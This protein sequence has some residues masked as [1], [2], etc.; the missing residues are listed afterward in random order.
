MDPTMTLVCPEVGLSHLPT[1]LPNAAHK[2]TDISL[3]LCLAVC[4]SIP[5][6]VHRCPSNLLITRQYS[7]LVPVC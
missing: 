5:I 6:P 2:Q 4:T 3:A 7:V 1:T